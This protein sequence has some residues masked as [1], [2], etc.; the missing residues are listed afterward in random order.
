METR[1]LYAERANG[2]SYISDLSFIA[3]VWNYIH[4]HA[5]MLSPTPKLGEPAVL[6]LNILYSQ[7]GMIKIKGKIKK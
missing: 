4:P 7:Q 1:R 2:E 3:A 6:A 5:I